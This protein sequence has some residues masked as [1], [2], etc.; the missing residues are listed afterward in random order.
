M[1]SANDINSNDALTN[2]TFVDISFVSSNS[3]SLIITPVLPILRNIGKDTHHSKA[4]KEKSAI[5]MFNKYISEY[6]S[7][8][9]NIQS[10]STYDSLIKEDFNE[11][12]I[13]KWCHYMYIQYADTKIPAHSTADGYLSA[14]VCKIRSD[15]YNSNKFV[16]DALYFIYYKSNYYLEE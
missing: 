5:V 15:F 3:E 10:D 14:I 9:D 1:N 16:F 4:T 7:Q 11:N 6:H 2:E 8:F 12:L 13:G